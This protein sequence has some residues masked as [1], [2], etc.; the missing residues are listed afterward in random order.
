MEWHTR[1]YAVPPYSTLSAEG[2]ATCFLPDRRQCDHASARSADF[3]RPVPQHNSVAIVYTRMSDWQAVK[4]DM[5]ALRGRMQ[6]SVRYWTADPTGVP[7][8]VPRFSATQW[9]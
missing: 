9:S 8:V 1:R 4:D 5:G 2:R 3:V 6:S 7:H